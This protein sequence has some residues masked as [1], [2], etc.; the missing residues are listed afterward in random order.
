MILQEVTN[1]DFF[2]HPSGPG[3]DN[4]Q[5]II[6]NISTQEQ[7]HQQMKECKLMKPLRPW[8]LSLQLVGLFHLQPQ[9][10]QQKN[11]VNFLKIY[12][13][14]IMTCL[15]FN[16]FRCFF[17]YMQKDEDTVTLFMK[18]MI[19][20]WT[21]LIATGSTTCFVNCKR[22]GGWQKFFETWTQVAKCL[23]EISVRKYFARRLGT[24]L[25]C[26]WIL[27]LVNMIFSLYCV[28]TSNVMDFMLAPLPPDYPYFRQIF[29]AMHVMFLYGASAWIFPTSIVFFLSLALHLEFKEFHRSFQKAVS[30]DGEF[31]GDIEEFRLKH[32]AVC[33]LASVADDMTYLYNG[34]GGGLALT[35]ALL[36]VTIIMWYPPIRQDPVAFTFVILWL[37]ISIIIVS[38]IFF[39]GGKVNH[40]VRP[41]D[42]CVIFRYTSGETTCCQSGRR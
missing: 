23:D 1:I 24:Y 17:M 30:A 6:T 26:I 36:N 15:W 38:F 2:I 35:F 29:Y 42:I 14:V 5:N 31:E 9:S 32:Q 25:I 27:I 18:I 13:A 11:K 41:I 7:V 40:M 39:G 12:S 37:F 16:F 22:G 34:L 19:H 4:K 21:L 8:M 33:H 28:A 10:V 3:N 20:I